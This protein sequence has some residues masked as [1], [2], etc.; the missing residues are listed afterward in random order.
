MSQYKPSIEKQKS[1]TNYE[2][3][4]TEG[5][6]HVVN[7][8]TILEYILNNPEALNDEACYHLTKAYYSFDKDK[9]IEAFIC[10]YN[11][12]LTNIMFQILY[13]NWIFLS[14]SDIIPILWRKAIE[15][16]PEDISFK[17]RISITCRIIRY[18][19]LEKKFIDEGIF[20]ELS[21]NKILLRIILMHWIHSYPY[22][23]LLSMLLIK[24]K[25][26]AN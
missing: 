3:D 2:N 5:T 10:H 11:F 21:S 14:D 6:L 25:M 20:E 22:V 24:R 15:V 4:S 19:I 26:Y 18:E 7:I 13:K 23:S 1:K 16:P 9:Y 17:Q 8:D 12:K